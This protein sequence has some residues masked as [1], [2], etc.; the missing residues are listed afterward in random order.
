MRRS[1][2]PEWPLMSAWTGAWK[3]SVPA[4]AGTSCTRPSVMKNAPAMRSVGTSESVAESAENS[5]VPSVS[6]SACPASATR[7]SRPLMARNFSSSASRARSV[8]LARSPK[9]WLGLLS[10]MTA[11]T[12]ESGSRA[13]RVKE[14]LASAS[15]IMASAAARHNA[16]RARRSS[17]T[18]TMT[19]VA[20]SPSHSTNMGTRGVNA[21]PYCVIARAFQSEQG[22]GPDQPCSCRSGCTSR[23]WRQPGTRIRAGA[24]RPVSAEASAGRRAAAPTHRRGRWR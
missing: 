15:R 14:G 16:P 7:T 10:T 22:H 4:L 11:A 23:C 2:S 5:F 17:E 8:C 9:L 20:A 12:E 1:R 18:A 24:A 13:S 19:S 3:P 21:M 6:P